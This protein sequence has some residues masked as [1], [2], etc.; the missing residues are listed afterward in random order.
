MPGPIITEGLDGHF[1]A[2]QKGGSF[3]VVRYG[4]TMRS[5]PSLGK[6]DNLLAARNSWS[7]FMGANAPLE[8][9]ASNENARMELRAAQ[10]KRGADIQNTPP[11]ITNPLLNVTNFYLPQ[12][13]RVLNQWL[14]YYDRF[15]PMVGT[16]LDL[17]SEVPTSQYTL[18]G[19]DD[20]AI[21]TV[22]EDVSERCDLFTRTLE[23]IREYFL[24]GESI[25]FQRW[26]E[27]EGIFDQVVVMN[28]DYIHIAGHPLAYDE[29]MGD[30]FV[31][32]AMEPDPLLRAIVDSNDE[33][34]EQ[35]KQFIDPVIRRA[36]ENNQ[37]V[38]IESFYMAHIARR[39][40]PYDPRGTS[41]VLRALKDLLYE[42]KLRGAQYAIADRM[43]TP[44][45]LAKLGDTAANYVPSPD[46]IRAFREL[47][48][49]SI[50]MPTPVI[51]GHQAYNLDYLGPT[52]RLLPLIPEFQFIED[53]ILTALMI[54][55]AMTH[56]EGPC[57][58]LDTQT[59]TE[60]G[61]KYLWEIDPQTEK[62]ATY[63]P[64]NGELEYHKPTG[65]A[66]YEFEGDMVHFENGK[67]D[68]MV[69]PNHRVWTRNQRKEDYE[70]K[71][72]ED[73]NSGNIL[74][75]K[76]DWKGEDVEFVE[77]SHDDP[78]AT[79]PQQIP[80][81]D[82]MALGGW[83]VSEGN[84]DFEKRGGTVFD[85][86]KG[87][88]AG[89]C[90][91]QSKHADVVEAL[92]ERLPFNYSKGKRGRF[93]ITCRGFAKKI[94]EDFGMG[95]EGK[96]I[97]KWIRNLPK[98]RL[99][100]F[101]DNAMLGDGTKSKNCPS[102]KTYYTVSERLADD[103]YEIVYK[104]G[105][106]PRLKKR[107]RKG[108][109]QLQYQIRYTDHRECNRQIHEH[110]LRKEDIKRVPYEGLVYCFEVPNH[111]YV[112]RR[113]GKVIITGNTF[114]TASTAFKTF[115]L[116]SLA[117]RQ[118]VVKYYQKKIFAAIAA[119][120]RFVKR[121]TAEISHRVKTT[122]VTYDTLV[123]PEFNWLGDVDLK[124]DIQQKQL[125]KQMM[126]KYQVPVYIMA[127][128]LDLDYNEM[129][130]WLKKEQGTVFDPLYHKIREQQAAN[131]GVS[132]TGA[133][134]GIPGGGPAPG[135]PMPEGGG[136]DM[137]EEE[138]GEMPEAP[139]GEEASGP[140]IKPESQT[141]TDQQGTHE[142][143]LPSRESAKSKRKKQ[144]VL[145]SGKTIAEVREEIRRDK[146]A[147]GPFARFRKQSGVPDPNLDPASE[148]PTKQAFDRRF[149]QTGCSERARRYILAI[150]DEV[151]QI[152]S[153]REKEDFE[154]IARLGDVAVKEFKTQL[155]AF[156][157]PSP[158]FGSALNYYYNYLGDEAIE[159]AE[160][161][162]KEAGLPMSKEPIDKWE[163]KKSCI[164]NRYRQIQDR[165]E[166]LIEGMT[167]ETSVHRLIESQLE[168]MSFESGDKMKPMVRRLLGKYRKGYR[169][170][171]RNVA[172][173]D[174]QRIKLAVWAHHGVEAVKRAVID[175][176]CACVRCKKQAGQRVAT[177]ALLECDMPV[178]DLPGDSSRMITHSDCQCFF[179][180]IGGE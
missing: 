176:E 94:Y 78:R 80:I 134:M 169:N 101:I 116:S 6:D 36:V 32:Y 88:I 29:E 51:I 148:V 132:E 28:P 12:D 33:Q 23:I 70:I 131:A 37:V 92:M 86:I 98:H 103:M 123:I 76:I 130:S 168:T 139:A 75:S 18:M 177:A 150:E 52:G 72:A 126:D 65:L 102:C 89:V 16:A 40:D 127:K 26:N 3:P 121:T 42:D 22:Y 152:F 119:E 162:L 9:L 2:A 74:T 91:T 143:L 122:P 160:K 114:S 161:E 87:K 21:E 19:I 100:V 8:V 137:G 69:T 178:Q 60:N 41:I 35:I 59:L 25:P 105:N 173:N 151:D 165:Y 155:A 163:L 27:N 58:S 81:D 5:F 95:S 174:F 164:E 30:E 44:M 179:K 15:H 167:E 175:D 158:K 11:E 117:V 64:E 138:P 106:E 84:L 142:R 93:R 10:Q 82:Y 77:I 66:I 120:H 55:K 7:P 115:M 47:I 170:F 107:V 73:V 135:S 109:R 153:S 39:A 171:M 45:L 43:A 111:L 149:M 1:K 38:P 159:A 145:G 129:E 63:N 141:V 147:L 128:L 50:S 112:V 14:R 79:E 49:E 99:Q 166:D 90:I 31:M 97:A 172:W 56:G 67:V 124:N 62:I 85:T 156:L 24:I 57:L 146:T 61:F 144:K 46:E 54:G 71:R 136:E 96:F 154:R 108:N 68:N 110:N 157:Y 125:V 13:R 53:R 83:Y 180:L 133:G 20:P 113:N 104:S 17:K 4:E 34:D 140:E 118:K 48:L